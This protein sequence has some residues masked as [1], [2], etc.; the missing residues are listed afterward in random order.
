MVAHLLRSGTFR[1]KVAL[2]VCACCRRLWPLLQDV[3]LRDAVEETERDADQT[4]FRPKSGD[5][6]APV[7]AAYAAAY[8]PR[9]KTRDEFAATA[10]SCAAAAVLC[11][12]RSFPGSV[13]HHAGVAVKFWGLSQRR[14][15]RPAAKRERE[16]CLRLLR[17][18]SGNPFRPIAFS[19]DWRTADVVL[20]SRGMY[21]A[22][23]FR[24]MPILADALQDAGCDNAALPVH[25]RGAGPHVRGCRVVDC[26][27]G[28]E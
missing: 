15:G 28:K 18:E 26:V 16:A 24:A 8:T 1:R 13:A 6:N 4:D 11:L 20:L 27:L 19:P 2:F 5:G 9:G 3:R 10:R 7:W 23:D 17:C 12:S 21:E 22:C 25:R 14:A